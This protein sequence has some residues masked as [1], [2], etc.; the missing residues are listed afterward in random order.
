[1]SLVARTLVVACLGAAALAGCASVGGPPPKR[2]AVSVADQVGSIDRK[3]VVGS[4]DCHELNPYPEVPK[5][6]IRM[7]FDADGTLAS[8]GTAAMATSDMAVSSQAKWTVEGEQLVISDQ[9]SSATS[10]DPLMSAIGSIGA[11]IANKMSANEA[12]QSDVL[13]LD[14]G[15]LV[16]RGVGVDDPPI[17]SCTR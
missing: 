11:T 16:M 5:H 17:L 3:L 8:Q 6:S 9:T 14:R 1:M 10:D 2:P 12:M 15:H 13:Q 4:W 7:T